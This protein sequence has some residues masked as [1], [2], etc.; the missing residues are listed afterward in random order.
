LKCLVEDSLN[1]SLYIPIQD[2][3][4][5][6]SFLTLIWITDPQNKAS[7]GCIRNTE[8]L[9]NQ[10]KETNITKKGKQEFNIQENKENSIN[11]IKA[12]CRYLN[13]KFKW[14]YCFYKQSTRNSTLHGGINV[15]TA[16]W[17]LGDF[18]PIKRSMELK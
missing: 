3:S 13:F 18:T 8:P 17:K 2:H 6:S 11:W 16:T 10:P 5:L 15:I 9:L 14:C 4:Q 1:F 12:L 7:W